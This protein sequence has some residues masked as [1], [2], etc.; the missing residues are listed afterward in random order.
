VLVEIHLIYSEEDTDGKK[1][2]NVL[3]NEKKISAEKFENNILI[4][5]NY[6][7]KGIND[8]N[9]FNIPWKYLF[10]CYFQFGLFICTFIWVYVRHK[11]ESS[12][13]K[14]SQLRKCLHDIH[15]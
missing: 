4:R 10:C 6:N 11:L 1:K 5:E 7:F 2:T 8:L 14:D 15:L 12:K 9:I 13:R 3:V